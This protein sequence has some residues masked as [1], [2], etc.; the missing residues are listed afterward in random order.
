[1]HFSMRCQICYNVTTILPRPVAA[2]KSFTADVTVTNNRTICENLLLPSIVSGICCMYCEGPNS[3]R[4]SGNQ[5][6]WQFSHRPVYSKFSATFLR[7]VRRSL[8]IWSGHKGLISGSS[9]WFSLHKGF[10]VHFLVMES[11]LLFHSTQTFLRKR[12]RHPIYIVE[13]WEC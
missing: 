2:L 8:E 3:R 11:I 13:G 12:A 9:Y 6:Q 1:M 5:I 7:Y 10:Q 4:L